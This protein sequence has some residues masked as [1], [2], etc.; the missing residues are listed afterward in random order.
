MEAKKWFVWAVAITVIAGS[1]A[2]AEW[3]DEWR[4]KYLE[5]YEKP[6]REKKDLAVTFTMEG[7]SK[8]IW[9]GFDMYDDRG[10]LQQSIEM[11]WF[12]TGFSAMVWSVM[13]VKEEL[14]DKH[15]MRYVG[16]YSG[17][18]WEDSLHITK[19][20]IN[21]IYYDFTERT[22][23]EKDAQEVGMEFSWP[24]ACAAGDS[25][26]VP[27][28]YVGK[29]WA[30]QSNAVNREDGGWIHILGL[31]YEF[32]LFG[33]GAE[34]QVGFVSAELVYNDGLWNAGHEWSHV[35]FGVGTTF[36]DAHVTVRPEFKYQVSLEDG[37]NNEDEMWGG[38]S[39]SYRF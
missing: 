34:K 11:D 27:S 22:S 21:F 28:Y 24:R 2:R 13:P 8:Y 37:V 7:V 9:R 38:V 35:V 36:R 31:D 6:D 20:T 16:A 23:N 29:Y 10:A 1:V 12:D 4:E 19:Y 15:E 14:G 18:L 39:V 25:R 26:L 32:W 5:E 30:A 3:V 33:M 17:V